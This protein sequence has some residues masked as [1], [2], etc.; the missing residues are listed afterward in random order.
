M[1]N[2]DYAARLAVALLACVLGT[3]GSL[4]AQSTCDEVLSDMCFSPAET[5]RVLDGEFVTNKVGTVSERD[6]AFSIAFLVKAPADQLSEQVLRGARVQDDP[7]V[8]AYGMLSEPGSLSDFSELRI[9]DD[10]ARALVAAEAG[11]SVNRS[12][13]EHARFKSMRNEATP[14]IQREFQRMLLA[15]Y[16]A[17]RASGLS[18]IAPY[19]RAHGATDVAQDLTRAVEAMV[20]LQKHLPQLHAFLREGPRASA[21]GIQQSYAWMRSI[22]RDKP[23][24]ALVHFLVASNGDARAVVRRE[25]YVSTGYNAEMSVASLMPVT[26]G[27]MVLYVSHAFSD[28]VAGSAGAVKRSIGSR[29]MADQMRDIFDRARKEIAR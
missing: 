26:G 29:I 10:E 21:T 15:R 28:Q 6:L 8:R 2:I 18:G 5:K 17:Y 22:I 3:A 7:Q 4:R 23:T 12:P 27:T 14:A 16:Q 1:A 13:E 9:T 11:E 19:A 25:F 20:A 24:Y